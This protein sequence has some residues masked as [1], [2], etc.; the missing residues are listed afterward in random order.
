MWKGLV[1]EQSYFPTMV[2][3]SS[4]CCFNS[5]ANVLCFL[6]WLGWRLASRAD[7]AVRSRVLGA[8]LILVLGAGSQALTAALSC[9]PGCLQ[10]VAG[11]K[12]S[13]F[14]SA[15][16]VNCCLLCIWQLWGIA[17]LWEGARG[18]PLLGTGSGTSF[19]ASCPQPWNAALGSLLSGIQRP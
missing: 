5:S 10:L 6:K 4:W 11:Q 8:A 15:T 12:E 9:S 13:R 18:P 1:G 17:P 14:P 16:P 3:R 7:V 19:P 2:L